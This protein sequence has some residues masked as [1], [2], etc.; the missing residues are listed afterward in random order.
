MA[1]S[2]CPGDAESLPSKA[3]RC[4]FECE[5]LGS[6]VECL[7]DTALCLQVVTAIRMA[8]YHIGQLERQVGCGDTTAVGLFWLDCVKE[9]PMLCQALFN[10]LP[11]LHAS[12]ATLFQVLCQLTSMSLRRSMCIIGSLWR[13]LILHPQLLICEHHVTCYL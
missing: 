5:Y 11:R 4:S 13:S 2:F 6:L 8:M 10:Y 7:N 1:N 9:V 3:K 12:P